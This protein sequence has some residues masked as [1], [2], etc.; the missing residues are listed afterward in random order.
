[1]NA[2][3]S[4]CSSKVWIDA[5]TGTLEMNTGLLPID[6]DIDIS[7]LQASSG[8]RVVLLFEELEAKSEIVS[9]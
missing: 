2:L 3:L 4:I 1:M 5:S 9:T 7:I 6:I 8:G